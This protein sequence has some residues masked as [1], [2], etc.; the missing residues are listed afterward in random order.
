[1]GQA[2]LFGGYVP[3]LVGGVVAV[4]PGA[5]VIYRRLFAAG[6]LSLKTAIVS[7]FLGLPPL[8]ASALLAL[9]VAR[10]IVGS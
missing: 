2:L 6:L 9:R 8:A 1:V 5:L 7:A 4:V 10:W 3:G